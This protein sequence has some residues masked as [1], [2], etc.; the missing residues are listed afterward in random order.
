V[1]ANGVRLHYLEYGRGRAELVILPG[2]TSPAITW[3]FVAEELA[4]DYHVYTMD[5]RG[6]GLSDKPASG[7]RLTDYAKDTAGF[8]RA[9]GLDR[10]AVLGHSM[11]A[12][13]AAA[14]GALYPDVRA[15]LLV[16]DPP[17]SGPGRPPYPTPLDFYVEGLRRARAGITIK[18]L[19]SSFPSWTDEQLQIRADWLATCDETAVVETYRGFHEEDFFAYW[20]KVLP[21]VLCMYGGKSPA[22]PES[23]TAEIAAANPRAKIVRVPDAGHMIPWDNLSGFLSETRQFVDEV[24]R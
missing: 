6:R 21:P 24:M 5:I 22:V 23:A 13:I 7:Y 8:I 14:F 2:I 11:G 17:L 19:R 1:S 20:Q 9:L 18:E 15:A 16:V 4:R 12:R 3:E 10:P